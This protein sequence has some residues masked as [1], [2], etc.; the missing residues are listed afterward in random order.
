MKVVA[1][2]VVALERSKNDVQCTKVGG[3]ATMVGCD[4]VGYDLSMGRWM[5]V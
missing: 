1:E 5:D 4:E 2:S 3:I